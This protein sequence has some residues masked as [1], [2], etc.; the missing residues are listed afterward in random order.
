[1]EIREMIEE[2]ILGW[3]LHTQKYNGNQ[4]KKIPI[5]LNLNSRAKYQRSLLPM[6]QKPFINIQQILF[7]ADFPADS[8]EK[9]HYEN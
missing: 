7:I 6:S 5:P 3:L 4:L 8:C 9:R 2:S 1:M